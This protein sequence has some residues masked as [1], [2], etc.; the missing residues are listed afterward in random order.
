MQPSP[1]GILRLR[2]PEA[3]CADPLEEGE[4]PLPPLYLL[5]LVL[6]LDL[7]ALLDLLDLIALLGLIALIYPARLSSR[8]GQP[9]R[10]VPPAGRWAALQGS[11][12]GGAGVARAWRGRACHF[13]I[14]L[15]VA[16]PLIT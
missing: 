10:P 3:R 12:A 2:K 15:G 5:K 4:G 11:Q 14:P 16:E 1:K 8:A 6:L 9:G 7:L 13:E